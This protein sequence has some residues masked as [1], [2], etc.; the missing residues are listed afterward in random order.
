MSA[1]DVPNAELSGTV[2]VVGVVANVGADAEIATVYKL[3]SIQ[4]YTIQSKIQFNSIQQ[5]TVFIKTISHKSHI[6][7]KMKMTSLCVLVYKKLFV[8]RQIVMVKIVVFSV[9]FLCNFIVSK[10]K[11]LSE[12]VRNC[13]TCVIL[14][15]KSY[16]LFF[17]ELCLFNVSLVNL[18]THMTED[19]MTLC[20]NMLMFRNLVLLTFAWFCFCGRVLL[21][22]V[23]A[24]VIY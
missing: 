7:N 10:S 16:L 14:G 9:C 20:P 1:T 5:Y 3:R 24:S 11:L 19:F 21:H 22:V 13:N 4:E 15:P 6:Y 18:D 8:L 12:S 17:F 2:Q 23:F